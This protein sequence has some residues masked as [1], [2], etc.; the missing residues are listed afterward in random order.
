MVRIITSARRHGVADQDI[1]HA[2][3]N[4]LYGIDHEDG[5]VMVV[6]PTRSGM[7]IEVGVV[8]DGGADPVAIH[9]MPLRRTHDRFRP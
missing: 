5:L 2:L 3:R 7:L 1:L 8:D 6:G 9:A 4:E